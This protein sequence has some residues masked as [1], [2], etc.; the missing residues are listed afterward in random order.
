[1]SDPKPPTGQDQRLLALLH[2]RDKSLAKGDSIGLP[3][4]PTSAYYHPGEADEAYAYTLENNPTWAAVEDQI[5]LLEDAP[6]VSFPSGMAAIA[7]I[8][9]SQLGAGDK[10]IVPS[11]GY[12]AVRALAETF[13]AP[14]GIETLAWPTA[15]F[16]NAPMDGAKLVWIET[17]SN[18]GLDVCDLAQIAER[19]KAAGALS[20][21]DNTTMT[22]LLQSPL[23]LGIDM[24]VCSDTKA[25]SGH[26]DVLF[27]HVASRS[28][29]LLEQVRLWRKLSGAIPGPFEA[30]QVH[31]GLETLDV[32]LERMCTNAGLIAQRLSKHPKVK[33]IRY[34]GLPNDP[35][36]KAALKQ[37]RRFGFL[38]GFEFEDGQTA[39]TFLDMCDSLVIAT[40]FGS[41]HSS[42]ERRARWGDNV[43]DGFVRL[44]VGCEPAEALWADIENA[45]SRL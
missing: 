28:T 19:A 17:P 27:G 43:A 36:H 2:H 26:G 10:M 12:F 31:R 9:Y 41:T 11:D 37:M 38:I 8:F 21:A 25:M 35:S 30:A 20:V 44:S 42:A 6:V 23:D 34:P 14:M 40:S 15:D 1:M 3:I 5:A 13:L 22:P 33:N 39:D 45:L 7:A 24:T 29:D 4:T 18:P 32:R 16:A